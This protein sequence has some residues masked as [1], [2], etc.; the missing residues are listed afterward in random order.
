MSD[1]TVTI[2]S[3]TFEQNL[4]RTTDQA[5]IIIRRAVFDL[6]DRYTA[7]LVRQTPR[8]RGEGSR[9]RL[10]RNYF[11]QQFGDATSASYTIKNDAPYLKWVLN[12]RGPVVA[13]R[14]RFLRFVIDGRVFFRRRVGPAAANPFDQQVFR[15]M[16]GDIA[17]TTRAIADQI[18]GSL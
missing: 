6:G 5:S 8:G 17:A 1:I 18:A 15:A 12:G 3:G 9:R 13:K 11:T 10:S 14:G 4:A 7:E 16:Q 2:D